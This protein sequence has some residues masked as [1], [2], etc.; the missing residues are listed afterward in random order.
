MKTASDPFASFKAVQ[1]EGWS[2]FAPLEALTT[3]P[4]ARLVRFAGVRSGQRVLDVACGTG[5]A[6]V[7]AARLGA[8]VSGL[9]LTPALL[10]RAR[11]N[12]ADLD[13]G[14]DYFL[15]VFPSGRMTWKSVAT[16]SAYDVKSSKETEELFAAY[17]VRA[18][19]REYS[20]DF[21]DF[22]VNDVDDPKNVGLYA[23]G[24]APYTTEHYAADGT[25]KP[26]YVWLN[27]F[28]FDNKTNP[29]RAGIYVPEN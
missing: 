14:A 3:P 6:A 29:G 7:T 11:E 13:S 27:S 2:S 1:K 18:D 8:R 20:L 15:S 4:A 19:G 23:L 25:K 9:D 22:P 12:A 28:Q 21:I 24:V 5:V 17:T 26:F 10:E 16:N